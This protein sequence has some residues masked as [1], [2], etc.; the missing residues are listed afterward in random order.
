MGENYDASCQPGLKQSA[1]E[2]A[3]MGGERRWEGWKSGFAVTWDPPPFPFHS[4]V[5]PSLCHL[6]H[7]CLSKSRHL[8]FP[9]PT[10]SSTSSSSSQGQAEETICSPS[11]HAAQNYFQSYAFKAETFST[12]TKNECHVMKIRMGQMEASHSS[13][14]KSGWNLETGVLC[15]KYRKAS[16]C[17]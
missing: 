3:D 10:S 15:H 1:S 7:L 8:M 6:H 9:A 12:L 17:R 16:L 13:Q 11:L 14:I 5:L 2:T 4:Y